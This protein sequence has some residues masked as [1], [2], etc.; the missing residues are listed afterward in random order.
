MK[1][2]ILFFFVLFSFSFAQELSETLIVT[3]TIWNFS[4]S[5]PT[6]YINQRTDKYTVMLGPKQNPYNGIAYNIIAQQYIKYL[7]SSIK[8]V[9][10]DE[11]DTIKQIAYSIAR[12]VK[13]IKT[14]ESSIDIV[15]DSVN[16]SQTDSHL[17]VFI[18][19]GTQIIYYDSGESNQY[20]PD[21][22]YLVAF[23]KGDDYLFIKF[24][25][26][27]ENATSEQRFCAWEIV[28]SI[29]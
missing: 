25:F 26:N 13:Y 28:K 4:L 10:H 21:P 14:A 9:L 23:T 16:E 19:Y 11:R 29:K 24:Y 12:S 1:I 18:V 7:Q 22:Y 15:I 20:H 5:I 17:P 8:Q 3:D 27:I 6:D 2:L